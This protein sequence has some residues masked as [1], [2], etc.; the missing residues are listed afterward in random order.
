MLVAARVLDAVLVQFRRDVG[1]DPRGGEPLLPVDG[2]FVLAGD[3]IASDQDPLDFVLPHL[4]L[5]L[6][7]RNGG[8][9]LRAE[10]PILE[11]EDADHRKRHVGEV[12]AGLL[13]LRVELRS[14]IHGD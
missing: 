13:H 4:L 1:G 9:D 6:A 5:E 14:G 2:L 10:P 12:E 8:D 7:V 3:L 11:E